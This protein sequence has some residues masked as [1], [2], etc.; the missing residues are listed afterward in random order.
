MRRRRRG[1]HA[2]VTNEEEGARDLRR[3]NA[4]TPA[5]DLDARWRLRRW[6]VVLAVLLAA[7][8]AVGCT[9][10]IGGSEGTDLSVRGVR[11]DRPA[12]PSVAAVRLTIENETDTGDA[13]IAVS[14]PDATRASVHRSVVDDAGRSTMEPVDRLEVPAETTIEFAPGGLHVMLDEPT[15]DLQVADEITLTFTFENA[16]DHT[17]SAP[18]VEPGT[19]TSDMGDHDG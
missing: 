11:V 3:S 12:N 16:G 7:T 13:L 5:D 18:V 19:S 8:T 2:A 15:R 9:Q 4:T 14:S 6:P 17:M 10:D 1:D